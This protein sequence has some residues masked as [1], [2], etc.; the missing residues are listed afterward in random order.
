MTLVFAVTLSIN[1]EKGGPRTS[2]Y[3]LCR[4]LQWPMP[5]FQSTE[6]KSRLVYID[7]QCH[8]LLLENIQHMNDNGFS[9][10]WPE[11]LQNTNGSGRWE[12]SVQQLC[13]KDIFAHS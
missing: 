7:D 2:L 9:S 6:Q 5:T 10:I 11:S 8:C 4:R 13:I 3:D 12:E 1:M